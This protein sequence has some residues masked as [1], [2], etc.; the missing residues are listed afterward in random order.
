MFDGSRFT[1]VIADSIKKF[2][3]VEAFTLAIGDDDSIWIG[4][5]S[6][7]LYRLDGEKQQ[8]WDR[9]NGLNSHM[10]RKINKLDNGI[11]VNNNGKL[12]Y[13]KYGDENNFVELP[14]NNDFFLSLFQ[15]IETRIIKSTN[16][17]WVDENEEAYY[18][19]NGQVFKYTN[20]RPELI[21][22]E[23]IKDSEVSIRKLMLDKDK[24]LWIATAANGL[25][26]FNKRGLQRFNNLPNNRL[27]SL[28]E[29][30]D[31]A[32]WVG[33]SGGLCS[34]SNGAFTNYSKMQGLINENIHLVAVDS[35]D[36]V[37]AIPY[38]KTNHI[39]YI[40]DS[41]AM[42]KKLISDSVEGVT[43]NAIIEDE[44][45]QLW[46]ATNKYI[47]E[48]FENDKEFFIEIRVDLSN[49]IKSF[50]VNDNTIWYQEGKYLIKLAE[51]IESKYLINE[52]DSEIQS[53]TIDLN[54]DLLIAD[55]SG[56]YELKNNNIENLSILNGTASCIHEFKKDELWVCGDG[57]WLKV[58]GQK[59]YF[60]YENG[61]TN[62]VNGHIHSVKNDNYGNI[63]ATSNSGIFKL[64][65][66]GLDK[67]IS[68]I[69]KNKKFIKFSEKDGMKSSEFNGN[70]TGIVETSD[71]NLWFASQGGVVMVDPER[72][73]FKSE[74][75]LK[76]FVEHLY[77]G[78]DL[79]KQS[80]WKN[81]SPG[82]KSVHMHFSSVYLSDS[83][84]LHYRYKLDPIQ[85][86]WKTTDVADFSEWKAGHYKLFVQ[87][88]YHE[89][90]WSESWLKKYMYIHIGI[91]HFGLGLS[92]Q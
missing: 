77:I 70:S 12:F 36:R 43:I 65:R 71:G 63:W 82:A 50:I 88:K 35:L 33:T 87:V 7:G 31:G 79:I 68:G 6:S 54:G 1:N 20:G 11:L 16:T 62:V 23:F 28:V 52:N 3:D 15:N 34:I 76:P 84:N 64:S 41:K 81:I 25:F 83:K 92:L 32:I 19:K 58:K 5:T 61:L 49:P 24:N 48:L 22:A 90:K 45:G 57:L 14:V 74:K 10:I 44:S 56:A 37:F 40:V 29:D 4:T 18:T 9:T 13:F 51:G 2:P 66:Q 75:E 60:D 17:M 30:E 85:Q 72:A 69:D 89:N 38:G 73:Q 80:E 8:H 46:I 21:I 42:N 91:R 86:Q 39:S 67:A 59:I 47:G 55:K 53:M 26:K 27:S 78:N